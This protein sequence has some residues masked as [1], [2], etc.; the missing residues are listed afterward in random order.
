VYGAIPFAPVKVTTGSVSFK[1]TALSP[2]IVAVGIGFT[3]ILSLV[4]TAH[5]PPSGVKVYSVVAVLLIAGLQVPVMP[6]VEING[7]AG[8]TVPAQYGPTAA[9]VG[10]SNGSMMIVTLV[11]AAHWP[12]A[13]VKVYSVVTVLLI[14][15]GLQVPVMPFVEINGSAG[16]TDPI[17]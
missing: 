2:D 7:K 3:L 13:G 1:Q 15:A 8:I 10:V 14:V 5:W 4:E 11:I 16:M 6:F 17:Q 9:K 12:S